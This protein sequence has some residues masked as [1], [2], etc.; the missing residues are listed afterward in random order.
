MARALQSAQE[1]LSNFLARHQAEL[2]QDVLEARHKIAK[3]LS[4][5]AQ[6]ALSGFARWADLYYPLRD[7]TPAAPVQEGAEAQK[8]TQTIVGIQ[9]TRSSGPDRGEVESLLQYLIGLGG[10]DAAA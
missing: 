3:E 5:D 6:A 1:D 7:L 4:K 9:T 10:D 2:Y 8:L